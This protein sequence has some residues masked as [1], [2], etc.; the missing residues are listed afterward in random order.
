LD[1][2]TAGT[3]ATMCVVAGS[4][5]RPVG[6]Y[7]ADQLGGMR[8]L[9]ALYVGVGLC[10]LGLAMMPPLALSAILMILTMGL[11]GAGNGAVFQVVPQRFPREIGVLTG[12]VGA[13]GGVGG[14]V[15]PSV[16]GGIKET[17]GGFGL[18]FLGFATITLG[19]AMT[20]G[21]VTRVSVQ[22]AQ[23]PAT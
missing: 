20:V 19:C 12:I 8:L 22:V 1:K 18:G 9:L 13:A 5:L 23:Q 14:F 16:L 7:F 4:F 3:I 10:M 11:L 21:W 17:T 15:L 6:G 2:V